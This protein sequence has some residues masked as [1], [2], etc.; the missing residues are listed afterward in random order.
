MTNELLLFQK[1]AD[2]FEDAGLD[3]T[4]PKTKRIHDEIIA[5]ITDY[6]MAIRRQEESGSPLYFD[7]QLRL[8]ALNAEAHRITECAI[9]ETFLAK[10][11]SKDPFEDSWINPGFRDLLA[12]QCERWRRT[13][14]FQ[15]LKRIVVVGGGALPQTQIALHMELDVEVVSVEIDEL[16]SK[17]CNQVLSRLGLS[18]LR[19]HHGSGDDYQYDNGDL[20]V[21]AT[22]V[23]YKHLIADQVAMTAPKATL[24]P[25]VPQGPHSIWRQPLD[26]HY[27]QK[28]GWIVLD[29]WAPIAASVASYTMVLR[30]HEC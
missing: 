17:R 5:A 29:R 23:P 8:T 30:Q 3:M 12:G 10:S 4:K 25:R 1:L 16:S 18:S 20:I 14:R 13:D 28:K 22:L 21:I 7:M 11:S 19:C 15:H 27:L 9:A 2:D 24:S 26:L 6:G